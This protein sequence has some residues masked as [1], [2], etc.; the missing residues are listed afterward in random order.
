M[1]MSLESGAQTLRG[2]ERKKQD[3][4]SGANWHPAHGVAGKLSISP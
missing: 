4:R 3:S 2:K 1:F